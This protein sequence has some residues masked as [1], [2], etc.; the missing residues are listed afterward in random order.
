MLGIGMMPTDESGS[1]RPHGTM[2]GVSQNSTD[3]AGARRRPRR[4]GERT[5]TAILD[6][7][8]RIFSERG[9]DAA[10][11]GD[12]AKAAGIRAPSL[13][14]YFDS[15]ES[16]YDAM[17][18]QACE[19]LLEILESYTRADTSPPEARP[20]LL[21]KVL[22]VFRERPHLARLIHQ[23]ALVGGPHLERL[24]QPRM[25]TLFGR[26]LEVLG[27]LPS[28]GRW[29]QDE[30]PFVGLAMMHV[31]TCYYSMAPLYKTTFGVDLL[32]DEMQ[33]K[34]ADFLMKFWRTF[35]FERP[36]AD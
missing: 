25:Q 10:T 26:T 23:E 11:L 14:E 9:F 16:L 30:V 18:E 3:S 24:L 6:H 32:S 34:H 36:S 27:R 33:D 28:G 21:A 15:K 29:T 19:P 20:N 31:C 13:Y 5:R 17:L 35:W 12:I 4:R 1:S 2:G 22:T 8:E 7:A